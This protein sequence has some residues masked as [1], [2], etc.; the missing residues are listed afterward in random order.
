LA[1]IIDE[2]GTSHLQSYQLDS[3]KEIRQIELANASNGHLLTSPT[4]NSNGTAIYWADEYSSTVTGQLSSDIWTQQIVDASPTH[5]GRWVAHQTTQRY[6]FRADGNSFHPQLVND[7]LFLL[8]TSQTDGNTTPN[9]I[10]TP[11]A[12]PSTLSQQQQCKLDL[13]YCTTHSST[14]SGKPCHSTPRCD[15]NLDPRIFAPQ[16][17]TMQTGRCSHLLQGEL[18]K[19]Y[20]SS[21]ILRL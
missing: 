15:K 13:R 12:T 17:D 18:R 19:P 11:D 20:P 14:N 6:A 1:A 7:T 16:I 4:A 10:S 21:T 3:A 9:P 5:A 8:S 2:K